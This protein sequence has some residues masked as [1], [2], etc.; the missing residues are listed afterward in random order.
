MAWYLVQVIVTKPIGSIISGYRTDRTG[1]Y[2]YWPANISWSISSD[3][4]KVDT[5]VD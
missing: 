4:L 3:I 5:I 2:K 1:H